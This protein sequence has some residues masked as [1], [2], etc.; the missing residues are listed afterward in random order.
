MI[1]LIAALQKNRGL[2]FGNDLLWKIPVDTK[3]FASLT[4]GHPVVMGRKTWDSIPAKYRPLPGRTNIVLTRDHGWHADGAMIADSINGA[5]EAAARSPGGEEIW[6]IGGATVYREFLPL[7]NELWLTLVDGEK[8]ADA[9]FPEYEACFPHEIS[10]EP[11]VTPDGTPAA[12]VR[13]G[14]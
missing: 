6:V 2:G 9:F 4:T 10:R 3:R 5:R 11:F 8:P 14:R 13:L 7:A 1:Y 12:F